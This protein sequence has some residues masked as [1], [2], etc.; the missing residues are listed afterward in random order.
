MSVLADN[1]KDTVLRRDHYDCQLRLNGC[2][3]YATE[4][5]PKPGV[6]K[7]LKTLRPP[8][9]QAACRDCAMGGTDLPQPTETG[10]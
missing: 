5:V 6:V 1:T 10:D 2:D 8:Q 3:R 9:L 4:T 7:G